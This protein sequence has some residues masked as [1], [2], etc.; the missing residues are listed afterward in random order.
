MRSTTPSIPGRSHRRSPSSFLRGLLHNR[1]ARTEASSEQP[2]A[3]KPSRLSLRVAA[4]STVGALLASV[5]LALGGV[6]SQGWI[7]AVQ[8]PSLV[9]ARDSQVP[10]SQ[11]ALREAPAQKGSGPQA[12]PQI[13]RATPR[14]NPWLG[15]YARD[16]V[17]PAAFPGA[18]ACQGAMI[19][20]VLTGGPAGEAGLQGAI[21]KL[22]SYDSPLAQPGDVIVA[23]DRLGVTSVADL[24]YDLDLLGKPVGAK[25]MLRIVRV[26]Q[27]LEVSVK[28]GAHDDT[29]PGAL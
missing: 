5:A 13:A 7:P 9:G 15:I 29:K 21:F 27:V 14:A 8:P 3:G 18:L 22:P 26:R 23:I 6:N 19:V 2:R 17:F 11:A 1:R 12:A 24:T 16:V 4:L 25:V 10:L 28:L 20:H